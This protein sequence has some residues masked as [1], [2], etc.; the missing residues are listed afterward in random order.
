M[1][2]NEHIGLMLVRQSST[3][4]ERNKCIIGP[5]QDDLRVQSLLEKRLQLACDFKDQIL[6]FQTI[7]ADGTRIM[8][9]MSGVE[10]D[11]A[12]LQPKD[13]GQ[14]PVALASQFRRLRLWSKVRGNCRTLDGCPFLL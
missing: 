7:P 1:D 14:R 9:P 6:F 5:G 11:P 2:R 3:L 8:P 4:L 10:H 12:D 13:S